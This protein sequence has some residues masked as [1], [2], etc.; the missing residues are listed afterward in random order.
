M[1]PLI[2]ETKK[3]VIKVAILTSLKGLVAV[4]VDA[5]NFD[6]VFDELELSAVHFL[7]LY[8]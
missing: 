6:R 1:T 8:L 3:V 2:L 5:S 7:D 4:D